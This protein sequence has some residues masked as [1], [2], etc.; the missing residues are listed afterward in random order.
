VWPGSAAAR[1][2][3]AFSDN[4]PNDVKVAEFRLPI[5]VVRIVSDTVSLPP[6]T[7]LERAVAGCAAPCPRPRETDGMG[8]QH[9]RRPVWRYAVISLGLATT[10]GATGCQVDVSGQTLPSPW[11]LRDDIQYFPPGPEFKLTEEA[12]VQAAYKRDAAQ[13][14]P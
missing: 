11:Y 1:R 3:G 8:C 10:L 14:P 5:T 2:D 12:A 4:F 9:E 6:R 7:A 13:V